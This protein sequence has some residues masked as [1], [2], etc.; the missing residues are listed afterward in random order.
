MWS[1]QGFK[2]SSGF[3]RVQ[4]SNSVFI[5]LISVPGS[6]QAF[7]GYFERSWVILGQNPRADLPVHKGVF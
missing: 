6:F 4:A 5:R 2:V 3:Y 1:S 7:L